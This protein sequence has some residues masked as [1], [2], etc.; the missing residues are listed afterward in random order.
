MQTPNF[1]PDP[2]TVLTDLGSV[3]SEI[4]NALAAAAAEA[5]QYIVV[6]QLP[7]DG[8]FHASLVRAHVWKQ[9]AEAADDLG[10]SIAELPN[11]GVHLIKDRYHV[12]ILKGSEG[13]LA[14]ARSERRR[15]FYYQMPLFPTDP[16]NGV[17]VNLVVQWSVNLVLALADIGLVCP[18]EESADGAS[19]ENY[20][21]IPLDIADDG[22][23]EQPVVDLPI[24]PQGGTGAQSV[25]S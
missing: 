1:P 25:Q 4:S 18:K 9:L 20:W 19:V 6:Q 2:T 13:L 23:L 24:T 5:R 11:F 17:P 10:F 15:A 21:Y 16:A 22:D 12:K 14:P 7:Y 8:G 3:C